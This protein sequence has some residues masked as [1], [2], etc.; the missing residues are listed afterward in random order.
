MVGWGGK[1]GFCRL[2]LAS[3]DR[4]AGSKCPFFHKLLTVESLANYIAICRLAR[5]AV[6]QLGSLETLWGKGR[7]WSASFTESGSPL[8]IDSDFFSIV[9]GRPS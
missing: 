5:G 3:L 1:V 9:A 8:I 6:K 7:G 4:Q 2:G